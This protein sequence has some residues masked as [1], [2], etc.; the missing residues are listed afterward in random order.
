MLEFVNQ[1]MAGYSPSGKSSVFDDFT[2]ADLTAY[3]SRIV[4][5]YFGACTTNPCGY[6]RSDHA[7][8]YENGFPA[9]YACNEVRAS[10]RYIHSPPD[11][12]DT[13]LKHLKVRLYG[14]E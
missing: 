11:S 12:F 2:D 1:D 14:L 9:V 5:E 3:V 7:S 4:E 13:V 10:S 6:R 8:A